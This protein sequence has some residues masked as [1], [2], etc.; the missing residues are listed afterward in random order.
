MI[1]T[2]LFLNPVL[3]IFL[4]FYAHYCEVA[5]E[6]SQVLIHLEILQSSLVQLRDVREVD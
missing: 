1:L 2:F 6:S 3:F 5:K 4:S